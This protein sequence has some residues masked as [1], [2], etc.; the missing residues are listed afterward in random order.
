M[1]DYY[2]TLGID[3]GASSE[4]IKKAYRKLAMK[5]HPDKNPGDKSAELK[6]KE[7]AEAYSVLNDENKRAQFD[8]FGA[9][10]S[11]FSGHGAGGFEFDLSDALRTFMSGFGGG[12]FGGFE[13]FFGGGG[14]RRQSSRG[15]D[16]RVNLPLTLEEIAT[17]VEKTIRVKR[18]EQCEDCRGTGTADGG[19]TS[20][21]PQCKGSGEI[22]QVQRTILGQMVNIQEC[23]NCGGSGQVITRPCRTCHGDG[24][25]KKARDVRIDVP[26]GVA[27]GNYMTLQGEGNR[28]KKGGS[29]GDLIV[30]F[31]ETAHPILTRHG[32]D[33]LLSVNISHAEASLGTT[34][35]VP[36][37]DGNARLKFPAGIQSGHILR[38]RTKGFPGLRGRGR[39]DQLVRIQVAT[40][41]RLNTNLSKLYEKLRDEE[42]TINHRDRFA[43][44]T[45]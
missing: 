33:V 9:V 40:P 36:T 6:F 10:G 2:T 13:D 8:Q 19:S 29:S 5:Y 4:D 11:D 39:G 25:I 32:R 7:A 14:R 43:K 38:M 31:E 17:G 26:A 28:G 27:A 15:G 20:T 35:E 3:R 23:R 21:C 1:A 37:L 45:D 16:L 34:V 41:T 24:R 12:G 42:S 30:L 22:R 44:F 18:F